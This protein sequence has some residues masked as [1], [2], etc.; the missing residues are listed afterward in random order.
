MCDCLRIYGKKMENSAKVKIGGKGKYIRGGWENLSL[1]DVDGVFTTRPSLPFAFKYRK[2]KSNG[3]EYAN[4]SSDTHVL[5][6][7]FCPFC[8]VKYN[9]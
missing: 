3:E 7:S 2:I 9:S 5:F 6:F 4:V 1:V 8:G